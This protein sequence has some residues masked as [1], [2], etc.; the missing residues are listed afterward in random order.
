VFDAQGRMVRSWRT[1]AR[2]A[3]TTSWDGRDQ[4]GSRIGRG[5]Y[6]LRLE[7]AARADRVKAVVMDP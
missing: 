4:G 6:F 2:G 1:E 3:G 7:G 5:I